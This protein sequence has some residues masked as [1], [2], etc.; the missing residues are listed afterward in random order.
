MAIMAQKLRSQG[1]TEPQIDMMFKDNPA[2]LL[3]LPPWRQTAAA[4]RN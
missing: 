4:L 3:G 2:K 1:I